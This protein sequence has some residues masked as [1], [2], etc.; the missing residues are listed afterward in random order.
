MSKRPSR[1]KPARKPSAPGQD[2]DLK[3]EIETLRRDLAEAQRQLDEV[4]KIGADAYMKRRMEALDEARLVARGQALDAATARN[5]AEAE[6]RA[7]TDAIEKAPG[8][9]GW[10]LRHARRRL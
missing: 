8:F 10:L 7:L 1:P 9:S 4:A 2:S 3:A 5:K 6:L